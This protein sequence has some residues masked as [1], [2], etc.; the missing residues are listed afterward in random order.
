[1]N[2][3]KQDLKKYSDN[4]IYLLSKYLNTENNITAIS[5]KIIKLYNFG[6]IDYQQCSNSASLISMEDWNDLNQPTLILNIYKNNKK[7]YTDCYNRND[8]IQFLNLPENSFIKWIPIKN[9]ESVQSNGF[10]SMPSTN[11][12]HY[13]TK[14]YSNIGNLYIKKDSNFNKLLLDDKIDKWNL[15]FTKK[16]RIGSLNPQ[17]IRQISALHGQEPGEDIY[18][19]IPYGDKTKKETEWSNRLLSL[20]TDDD[21]ELF[22]GNVDEIIDSIINT[23]FSKEKIPNDSIIEAKAILE[24]SKQTLTKNK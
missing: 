11:P 12:K 7:L 24:R 21:I 6:K 1:M 4:D 17:A 14:I 9:K 23:T 15:E 20:V 18:K 16:Q 19:L 22:S 10:G 8:L 5:K 3:I 2:L 13:V